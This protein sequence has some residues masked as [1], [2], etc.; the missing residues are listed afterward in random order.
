VRALFSS[1]HAH[2]YPHPF[3]FEMDIGVAMFK[4]NMTKKNG[5]S[6]MKLARKNQF[7]DN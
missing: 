2:P 5:E 1:V 4:D 7:I 3:V 6:E